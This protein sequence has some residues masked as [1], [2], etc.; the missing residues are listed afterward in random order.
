MR[1]LRPHP[2]QEHSRGREPALHKGA[3]GQYRPVLQDGLC[4]ERRSV[5]QGV[6]C[7]RGLA[8]VDIVDN[9]VKYSVG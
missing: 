2:D 3:R 1:A 9:V 7:G 5:L 4:N 8:F 6:P